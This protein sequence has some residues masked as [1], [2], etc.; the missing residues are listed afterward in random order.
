MAKR[1]IKVKESGDKLVLPYIQAREW[2]D[3]GLATWSDNTDAEKPVEE[4][5]ATKPVPA[6]TSATSD[7]LQP[8]ADGPTKKVTRKK[9]TAKKAASEKPAEA[10][11]ATDDSN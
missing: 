8:S 11:T 5:P 1:I 10:A 7:K 3:A 9:A 4:D 2:I 6:S